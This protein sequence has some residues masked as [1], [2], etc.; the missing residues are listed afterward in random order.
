M[1]QEFIYSLEKLEMLDSTE[2]PSGLIPVRNLDSNKNLPPEEY[3]AL[4]NADKY[5]ANYVYF[6]KFE[7]RPSVPQVYLYDYTD[8]IGI[9]EV[10]L[11]HLHKKLYS[12][13]QVPMFFVV[14]KKDVRIFNCFEAP[15][16]GENLK[17]TPLT[18]IKI[19][20]DLFNELDFQNKEEFEAF[21]GKLF[22]NGTFWE[23]SKYKDQFKFSNS[24]YEKLLTELKQALKDIISKDILPANFA[25]RIIVVSILLKY[26]E[27]R[28]DEKGNKVFPKDFFST[29][30]QN[31]EK[32]TDVFKETGAFLMLLDYLAKHFNG[33]IFQLEDDE[34]QFIENRDLTRFGQFLDGETE[35]N[36][37]VFW[38]L[39]SFNDLPVELIS[40]IYEEFLGKQ[41]GVVYTPPYLVNFLLDEAMPFSNEETDFKI[42]D[43]ACGSGVFLVGAYRR[44]IY[45]WRKKNNWTNPNL[46]TLKKLLR[47][48]IFGV[49]LNKE[50]ADLTIFS[51]SLALCDE[52]TPLQIWKDL[53]FDDLHKEN[54]IHDDFFNVI[55]KAKFQNKFDLV[56]GNPPF[57]AKLTEAAKRIETIKARER[58]ITLI[59]D[60]KKT[61]KIPVKLPDNQIALLF[62]EQSVELC[63]KKG[64][65][66]FIQPSTALL[67]NKKSF[68]FRKSLMQK[69]DIPEIIDF[70]HLNRVLFTNGK[71]KQRTGDVAVS[72][73]FL[74]NAPPNKK[75]VLHVIPKRVKASR[76]KIYFQLDSYDFHQVS[77]KEA[78][79]NPL[80]WKCNLFGGRRAV[81][82]IDFFNSFEKL[83]PYL[84]EKR[85]SEKWD[86]G[87]GFMRGK[88]GDKVAD[89]LTSQ[90]SLL[91]PKFKSSKIEII[92]L[93]TVWFT[94]PRRPSL[95]KGPILLIKE[96]IEADSAKI[97]IF[98]SNSNLV[99]DSRI[100]GIASNQNDE[101]SLLELY[102]SFD[103]YNRLYAF[104]IALTSSQ[105][106]VGLSSAFRADDIYGLPLF[107]NNEK[108]LNLTTEEKFIIDD[109]LDF[110]LDF[111]RKGENSYIAKNDATEKQ[112]IEFGTTFCNVLRSV[113]KSIKPFQYFETDSYICFPFYFGEKPDI[114]FSDSEQ[115]EKHIE[116]LVLRNSGTSLRLTRIVRI[117]EG[118]VIYLIKPKKLRYWLKSIAL[119]DADETFSDLRKQGF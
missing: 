98:H 34:R 73:I 62:L 9:S 31:A 119:R 76:E 45:R 56:I 10:E 20:S 68:N 48:N 61:K 37:F 42:L 3:I 59:L 4:E 110:L 101:D 47:E 84:E 78:L 91:A 67:Y 79:N 39:Y 7:N 35:G 54:I 30:A 117:Y 12:S 21:S 81:Q 50:A 40:N 32:F 18:T 94:S 97:P 112:M 70:S 105:F 16:K 95:Y 1:H 109:T 51:L 15:A 8:K 29:F 75:P 28:K 22:D 46:E 114:D 88:E 27:E 5:G 93:D 44:L 63:K 13:G 107:L 72:A 80:I 113:Y 17:Y 102:R 6:R 36:Q 86:Y 2:H 85:Q 38:R 25:R 71:G 118:N 77:K 103:K 43:P 55:S 60:N 53:K 19:A 66:C 33:G 57:E 82:L 24:V 69:F 106:S 92:T 26:L 96:L 111:K 90:K 89:Y 74:K 65:V 100:V 116:K 87:E 58:N 104:F 41:P 52:L 108:D 83:G 115:A 49:E 11:T 99:F 23:N 14:T 64:L